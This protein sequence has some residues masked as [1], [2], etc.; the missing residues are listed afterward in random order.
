VIRRYIHR[1]SQSISLHTDLMAE[2]RTVLLAV[3]KGDLW[4]AQIVWPNGTS[5]YV[6]KFR[7]E[8]EAQQWIDAH[9]SLTEVAFDQ[10]EIR[11]KRKSNLSQLARDEGDALLPKGGVRNSKQSA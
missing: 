4:R 6:G 8:A 11:R 1:Q 9:R 7:S 10:A 2:L 3:R 5:N